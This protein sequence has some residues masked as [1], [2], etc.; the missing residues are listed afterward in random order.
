MREAGFKSA[1]EVEV[2]VVKAW[3]WRERE[4]QREWERESRRQRERETETVGRTGDKC[5]TPGR[6]SEGEVEIKNGVKMRS[7]NRIWDT[8][9][10][11]CFLG[12]PR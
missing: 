12:G 2:T 3:K 9:T 8:K 1:K 4:R 10:V 11:W 7:G 5:L 6:E